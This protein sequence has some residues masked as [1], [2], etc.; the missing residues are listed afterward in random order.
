MINV[1]ASKLQVTREIKEGKY[2]EGYFKDGYVQTFTIVGTVE[3]LDGNEL[4][5][6]TEAERTKESIR[7]YTATE[8]LTVDPKRTRK[9]DVITYQGKKFEVHSV[10]RWTQLIP[11]FA[12][13]AISKTDLTEED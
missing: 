4:M 12:A 5:L 8:L 2:V 11:H 7:I 3:P 1:F 10:K 9:A 6:L 13:I